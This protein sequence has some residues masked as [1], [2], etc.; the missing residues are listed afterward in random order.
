LTDELANAS[1]AFLALKAFAVTTIGKFKI[2]L[3]Q[4]K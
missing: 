3:L 1:L 4:C 2:D